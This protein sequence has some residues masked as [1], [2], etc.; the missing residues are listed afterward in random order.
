[1][2]RILVTVGSSKFDELIEV[3]DE[4]APE[5]RDFEILAQIGAGKYIP[6]NMKY[7]RYSFQIE[8]L[9][10]WADIVISHDGAGTLFENL[11]LGN[12]IIAVRN[13]K[14]K[15]ADDLGKKLS[16]E[17]YVIFINVSGKEELKRELRKVLLQQK[18]NT[19]KPY[20]KPKCNIHKFLISF[21]N[22]ISD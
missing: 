20:K 9:Y 12:K 15:G 14:S 17:G 3:V 19:L 21:I 2:K 11:E 16:E 5:L 7:I 6:R 8:D 18:Y 10:K 22:E 13:W 1:M 4:L